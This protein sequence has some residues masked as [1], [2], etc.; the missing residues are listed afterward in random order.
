MKFDYLCSELCEAITVVIASHEQST[1]AMV[2]AGE[3][4]E[5]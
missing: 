3:W 1:Y 2:F 4:Y 5:E